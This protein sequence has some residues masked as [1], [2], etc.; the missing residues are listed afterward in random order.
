[1][2]KIAAA[3][4]NNDVPK[5]KQVQTDLLRECDYNPSLLLPYFYPDFLDGEPM[6]LWSRPH[7]FAMMALIPNGSLTIAA[8]RQI[9]KCVTGDTKVFVEKDKGGVMPVPMKELFEELR[10]KK[11]LQSEKEPV[12]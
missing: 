9:G 11:Q 8:S 5:L 7:A 3:Y 4:A 10:E 2:G 1:M 12:K 6:T